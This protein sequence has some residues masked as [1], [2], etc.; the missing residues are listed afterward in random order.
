MMKQKSDF[1]GKSTV[2]V[3]YSGGKDSTFALLWAKSNFPDKKIVAIF[4]DTGVEFP[5]MTAHIRDVCL[6]VGVEYKIVKP[7]VDVWEYWAE[8]GRFFSLIFPECQSMLV[9]DPINAYIRTYDSNNVIV[10][11][12]SRG[13]QV[14]SVYLRKLKHPVQWIPR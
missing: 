4:S 10:I 6:H 3:I 8:K 1:A 7:E 11:D 14:R 5:G 9:Y 2:L 12:G 13:D